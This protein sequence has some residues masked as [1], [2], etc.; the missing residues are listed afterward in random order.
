MP[1]CLDCGN[2]KEFITAYLEFE[3]SIFDQE[4]CVDNYAGDRERL[5]ET[6]PPECRECDST[7]IEGEI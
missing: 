6:Y 3:V 4:N 2:T 5:D 1:K 7:N